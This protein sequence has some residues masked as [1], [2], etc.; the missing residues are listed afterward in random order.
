MPSVGWSL[1]PFSLFVWVVWRGG[2][3]LTDIMSYPF[4]HAIVRYYGQNDDSTD[5]LICSKC[6]EMRCIPSDQKPNDPYFCLTPYCIKK[7]CNE[8]NYLELLDKGIISLSEYS[9]APSSLHL[10][11]FVVTPLF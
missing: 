3:C 7:E 2:F 8:S 4:E 9:V 11:L 5:Y 1:V 6:F 10:P